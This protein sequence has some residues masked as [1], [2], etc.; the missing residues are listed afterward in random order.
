MGETAESNK[1]LQLAMNQ[2]KFVA[3]KLMS[4]KEIKSI[5]EFHGFGDENEAIIYVYY[6][7][8]TWQTEIGAI[9]WIKRHSGN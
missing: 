5:P 4:R 2:N 6:A 8:F 1:K 9:E 7:Q 3:S